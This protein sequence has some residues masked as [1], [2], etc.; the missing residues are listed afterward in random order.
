MASLALLACGDT[1]GETRSA[2]AGD[3]Q[4]GQVAAVDQDQMVKAVSSGK[5]GAPVSLKFDMAKRPQVG[6]ALDITIAVSSE[7]EALQQMQ[8]IVQPTDGIEVVSGAQMPRV[9]RPK[10]GEPYLHTVR[11]VPQRDGIFYVAAVVLVDG[12]AGSIARSFAIP[13]IVGDGLPALEKAPTSIDSTGERIQS[14]KA[15]Q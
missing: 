13:V 3:R 6:I 15:D 11:V 4:A 9:E 12:P 7:S 1:E 2:S 5:P 10:A 8:V 14:M